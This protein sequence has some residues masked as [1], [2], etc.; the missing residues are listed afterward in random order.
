VYA[1]VGGAVTAVIRA[2]VAV[3]TVEGSGNTVTRGRVA[4]LSFTGTSGTNNWRWEFALVARNSSILAARCLASGNARIRS[5]RVTIVAIFGGGLATNARR[6]G[7][8]FASV[9]VNTIDIGSVATSSGVTQIVLAQVSTVAGESRVSA[10]ST[11]NCRV[12]RVD[13]A[14]ITVRAVRGA[15][16]SFAARAETKTASTTRVTRNVNACHNDKLVKNVTKLSVG[17]G[18]ENGSNTRNARANVGHFA[19][20]SISNTNGKDDDSVVLGSSE[21]IVK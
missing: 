4:L 2:N 8:H 6:A 9:V 12:A 13:S 14:S 21:D 1:S 15:H 16:A 5:A 11:V 10:S 7:D 18:V 20:V 17:R 19:L 3:V